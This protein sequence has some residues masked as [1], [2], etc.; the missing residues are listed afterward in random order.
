MIAKR[1]APGSSK[2]SVIPKSVQITN[3][4][5][6]VRYRHTALISHPSLPEP[7]EQ[8]NSFTFVGGKGHCTVLHLSLLPVTALNR[9]IM[10]MVETSLVVAE[11][12]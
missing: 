11:G 9:Q 3:E 10:K 6:F 12:G 2:F 7:V 4:G 5:P 8:P 1:Q